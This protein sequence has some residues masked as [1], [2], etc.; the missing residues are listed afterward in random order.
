MPA[1]IS[2]LRTGIAGALNSLLGIRV[3]SDIP[4]TP[5]TPCAIAE[6]KR[7][8]YD[9]TMARGADEYQFAVQVLSGRADDR[10]AQARIESYVAGS[11]TGSLKAALEADPT[12]DGA[13]M[14]LRVL[15]AGGLQSYERS[16]GMSLLGVE[17]QI[18]IYA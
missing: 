11:G 10:T 17:F 2:D 6:L 12:L 9:T 1:A 3:Y 16:D 18:V 5:V 8:S 13:C 15:E 14:T 7:V 4:D